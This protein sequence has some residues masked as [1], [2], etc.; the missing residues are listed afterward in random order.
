MPQGY[1]EVLNVSV[2]RQSLVKQ[3]HVRLQCARHQRYCVEHAECERRIGIFPRCVSFPHLHKSYAGHT[4]RTTFAGRNF[5]SLSTLPITILINNMTCDKPLW[6]ND[7][8]I[9]CITPLDVVGDKNVSFLAAGR[10]TPVLIA[11]SK[12]L[13]EAKCA[14]NYYGMRGQYCTACPSP[15]AV[16]PGDEL[17]VPLV[18]A[19][20]GYW[21]VD[22][23]SIPPTFACPAG[24]ECAVRR[25]MCAV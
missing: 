21:L 23:P 14:A 15:G 3:Y 5:G 25:R 13:I 8:L 7:G 24:P 1:G 2:N 10:S 18:T 4:T 16:C 19:S 20:P 22:L 9:T 17:D 12:K 11:S 6:F